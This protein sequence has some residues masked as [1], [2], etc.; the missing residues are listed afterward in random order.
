VAAVA[1]RGDPQDGFLRAVDVYN[2]RLHADLVVLSACSTAVGREVN[3]EGLLGLSRAFMY[4][5]APRVV[6]SLWRLSDGATAELME[7][8]YAALARKVPPAVALREGQA[9]M[10]RDPRFAD[11]SAWAA[12]EVQSDWR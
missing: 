4:T 8:F 7:L 1:A 2:L 6:A 11:P 3:R 5:G 9:A 10:A 12:F